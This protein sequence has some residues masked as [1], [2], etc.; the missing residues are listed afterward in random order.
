MLVLK[1]TKNIRV[2]NYIELRQLL[3][4]LYD[5]G[6][7]FESGKRYKPLLLWIGWYSSEPVTGISVDDLENPHF[8]RY[9]DFEDWN[10]EEYI[11][12]FH[13]KTKYAYA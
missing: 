4:I 3:K 7:C 1:E 11:T 12:F 5:K 6:C 13:Y 8:L 10:G 2:N 9:C